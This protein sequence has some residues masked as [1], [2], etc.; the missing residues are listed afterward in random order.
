M[1]IQPAD[2][3]RILEAIRRVCV[4]HR[5]EVSKHSK[6]IREEWDPKEMD[7]EARLRW[8]LFHASR[9]GEYIYTLDVNDRHIDTAL[10]SIMRDPIVRSACDDAE[11][12]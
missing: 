12:R 3:T 11:A 1:R 9:V 4:E 2:R 8:D 7:R 5:R 6:F 10:R